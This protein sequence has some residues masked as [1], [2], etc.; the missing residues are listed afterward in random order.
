M[1]WRVQDS[2]SSVHMCTR[3]SIITNIL[4]TYA[5]SCYSIIDLYNRPEKDICSDL[6]LCIMCKMYPGMLAPLM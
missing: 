5:K 1:E 6:G 4:V 3:A 2:L